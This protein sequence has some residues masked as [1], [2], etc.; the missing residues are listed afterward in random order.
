MNRIKISLYIFLAFI[1]ATTFSME[2]THED[3]NKKVEEIQPPLYYEFPGSSSPVYTSFQL[4][5]LKGSFEAKCVTCF[6]YVTQQ[7]P[8]G[9]L[10]QK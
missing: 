9:P 5:N 6:K 8:N 4:R 2:Q 7:L 1:S 10:I 3:E